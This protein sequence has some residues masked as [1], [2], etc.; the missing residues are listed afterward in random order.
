MPAAGEDT[1]SLTTV[2]KKTNEQQ[3]FNELEDEYGFP[4]ATCRSLVQLMHEF[5]EDNYGNLRNDNQIIYHAVSS[6]EPPGK[7]LDRLRLVP[8]KTH[9]ITTRRCRHPQL[10]RNRR[11]TK[12]QTTTDGKRGI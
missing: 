4:R 7:P 10:T 3:L 6:D 8:R 12:T 9:H 2:W 1:K 11:I 5:I